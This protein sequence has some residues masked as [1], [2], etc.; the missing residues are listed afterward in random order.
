[1]LDSLPQE[2]PNAWDNPGVGK[3]CKSFINRCQAY[4]SKQREIHPMGLRRW[5]LQNRSQSAQL[6]GIRRVFAV[7]T[8]SWVGTMKVATGWAALPFIW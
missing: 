8:L 5:M 6:R 4:C 2:D 7:P 3:L 1:M